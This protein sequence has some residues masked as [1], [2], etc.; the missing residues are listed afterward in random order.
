MRWETYVGVITKIDLILRHVLMFLLLRD[1]VLP[2]M[3]HVEK[4]IRLSMRVLR[5]LRPVHAVNYVLN[6]RLY[7]LQ[8]Q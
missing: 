7:L 1:G 5:G 3:Q 8:P 2:C 6:R 4:V